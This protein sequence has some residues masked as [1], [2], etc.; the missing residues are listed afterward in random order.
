MDAGRL[1]KRH[2][3]TVGLFVLLL[4]VGAGA[5]VPSWS[6]VQTTPLPGPAPS[7]VVAHP[8]QVQAPEVW[9]MAPAPSLPTSGPAA[10][11]PSSW[12]TLRE[13][14]AELR[15]REEDLARCRTRLAAV[16]EDLGRTQ[17][18]LQQLESGMTV[19]RTEVLRRMV[20]LD[21]IGRGGTARLMLTS[22]DPAEA[23]FRAALVRRLVRADAE[24]ARRYGA[25]QQE[26]ETIRLDL[27]QKRNGQQALERQ[28]EERRQQLADEVERHRRL[29]SALNRPAA[30]W[31][32]AE[33]AR[34]E[35]L[36][37][38]TALDL[39]AV[40]PAPAE[41]RDVAAAAIAVPASFPMQDDAVHG[42][43]A[44]DVPAGTPVSAPAAGTVA[45]AGILAGYGPTV[46]LRTAAGEGL[47]LGH[48][49]DVAVRTGDSVAPGA[50][51]GATDRS[52]SP[53]LPPLLVDVVGSTVHES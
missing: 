41:L 16:D 1:G 7:D 5:Q 44:V 46:L 23:R 18:H 49:A 29:L 19:L 43:I 3:V 14:E 27:A 48:L 33:Q 11:S 34:G 40:E 32:L 42:G 50:I 39:R 31:A 52:Y 24:M 2:R 20:L 45:F 15:R 22:R 4:A 9:G 53:L 6:R 17:A 8:P 28:L 38:A 37:L 36:G 25:M 12:D 10:A 21:R 35:V 51:L 13:A 30:V 47:L 26:A